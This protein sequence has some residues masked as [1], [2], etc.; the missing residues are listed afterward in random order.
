MTK[1]DSEE[2]GNLKRSVT[3]NEIH[4]GNNTTQKTRGINGFTVRLHQIFK[5]KSIE[6]LFADIMRKGLAQITLS[7]QKMETV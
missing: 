2:I 7:I 3:S 4:E 5:M 1:I 6:H